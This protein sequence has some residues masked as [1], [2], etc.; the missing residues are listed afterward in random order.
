MFPRIQ[1]GDVLTNSVAVVVILSRDEEWSGTYVRVDRDVQP[2]ERTHLGLFAHW[3]KVV[4]T[5]TDFTLHPGN[6]AVGSIST[7]IVAAVSATRAVIVGYYY[8]SNQL[9]VYDYSLTYATTLFRMMYDNRPYWVC[10]FD[11]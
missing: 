8:T 1:A 9:E 2:P 4:M 3:P 11:L 7:F 5:S 10:N 6:A